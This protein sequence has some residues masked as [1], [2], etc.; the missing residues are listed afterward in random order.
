MCMLQRG[1]WRHLGR[2]RST[3]AGGFPSVNPSLIGSVYRRGAAGRRR[4]EQILSCRCPAS[5][6]SAS[7]T[8]SLNRPPQKTMRGSAF[9][10]G[11]RPRYTL[12]CRGGPSEG[13]DQVTA[14]SHVPALCRQGCLVCVAMSVG[15]ARI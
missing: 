6:W 3:D 12:A 15:C 1:P 10:W 5:R 13:P 11:Q 8:Q 4:A 14:Y 2:A 9:L 7:L